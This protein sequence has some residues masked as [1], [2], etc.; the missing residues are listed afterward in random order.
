MKLYTPPPPEPVIRL[1]IKKQGEVSRYLTLHQCTSEEAYNHIKKLIEAQ[2]LSVF[3]NG[4]KINIQI[5]EA[6][7]AKN[8]KATFLSFYGMSTK[9]L[10]DLIVNSL[11]K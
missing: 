11:K 9:E 3:P 8:G 6:I 5:R 10:E 7:G 4:D 1:L 2:N